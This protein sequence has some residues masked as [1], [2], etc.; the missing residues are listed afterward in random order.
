[1]DTFLDAAAFKSLCTSV[2]S[3]LNSVKNLPTAKKLQKLENLLPWKETF[4][5]KG[6]N[7][8]AG[9]LQLKSGGVPIVY[10][11]GLNPDFMMQNESEILEG[12]NELRDFCPHFMGLLGWIEMPV[13]HTYVETERADG[14]SDDEAERDEWLKTNE[15]ERLSLWTGDEENFP[16]RVLLCEYISN[17]NLYQVMKYASLQKIL[18]Q[19]LQVLAAL[20]IAQQELSFTHYDM[21]SEN[22]LVR[23]CDPN[24]VFVYLFDNEKFCVTPTHGFYSV[25][26]DMGNAHLGKRKNLQEMSQI[27]GHRSGH[28][29]VR[30]DPIVDIHHLMI[31]CAWDVFIKRGEDIPRYR[32]VL[33]KVIMAYRHLPIGAGSGWRKLPVHLLKETVI[34]LTE[35][36]PACQVSSFWEECA[37]EI[38]SCLVSLTTQGW[39]NSVDFQTHQEIFHKNFAI[40]LDYC[41]YLWLDCDMDSID[42][43]FILRAFVKHVYGFEKLKATKEEAANITKAVFATLKKEEIELPS[44]LNNSGLINALISLTPIWT[45]VMS[46]MDA[47]NISTAA[48]FVRN[49]EIKTPYEMIKNLERWTGAEKLRLNPHNIFHVFDVKG[50][51][52]VKIRARD[53][54]LPTSL[55]PLERKEQLVGEIRKF[56]FSQN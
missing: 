14:D 42:I 37:S 8:L 25:I 50:K 56:L 29:P 12:L 19:Q 55:K 7:G 38:C 15:V 24:I 48:D 4:K 41:D 18:S 20:Q 21:H 1:M 34:M 51:R 26:I 3:A 17:M 10:K 23:Q 49:A 32:Q 43:L 30:F 45:S 46:T 6:Y 39:Q 5:S 16:T 44:G 54:K 9:K 11:I 31:P 22:V 28:T 53:I 13:S 27:F 36:V 40:L 47:A 52:T 2:S 33:N 35:S